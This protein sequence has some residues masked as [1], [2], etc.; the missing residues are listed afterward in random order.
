LVKFLDFG[1]AELAERPTVAPMR[2]SPVSNPGSFPLK[3]EADGGVTHKLMGLARIGA[4]GRLVLKPLR[5]RQE[6]SG[7]HA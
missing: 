4:R 2:T 7:E 5:R 3:N 1:L 6:E